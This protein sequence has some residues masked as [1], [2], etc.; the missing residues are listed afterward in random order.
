MAS[1]PTVDD[2]LGAALIGFA[3]SC[4]AFGVNTNQVFTYFQRYPEDKMA[5]K[6][7]VRTAPL[8]SAGSADHMHA[9]YWYTITNYAKPLVLLTQP[10]AFTLISPS[11]FWRRNTANPERRCFAMRLWRFSQRNVIVTSTVVRWIFMPTGNTSFQDPFL[12][13]LPNLKVLA[14]FS[15]GAGVLTDLFTACA[16]SFFLRRFRTGQK[17]ADSLVNTLTIYAV[18]TGAFTSAISLLTLIFYDLRP[19]NFQFMA[20]Y[21][22]LSKLYAISFMCTLNTRKIIRGKGTDRETPGMT[23][24]GNISGNQFYISHTPRTNILDYRREYGSTRGE[25]SMSK[26]PWTTGSPTVRP[27]LE[28]GIHQEVSVSTDLESQVGSP[29]DHPYMR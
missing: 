18:N 8:K 22:I 6:L 15:L 14:S 21:F 25:T 27:G 2:T 11:I 17:R 28:I 19:R 13:V 4:V 26:D 9:V 3:F 7:M 29:Y 20:F 23:G 5:Y 16:L 10:V 12:A 24:S 1:I